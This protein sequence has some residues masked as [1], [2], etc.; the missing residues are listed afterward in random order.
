MERYQ[1]SDDP[2]VDKPILDQIVLGIAHELNNPNGF[3]RMNAMNLKK[4]VALLNPIL[5]EAAEKD[6][7]KK[8]GPYTLPTLRGKILQNIEDILG[9]S[10]RII[11]ISDRLKD[12]TSDA[13]AQ[14]APISLKDLFED[15]IKTHDFIIQRCA[16]LDFTW[17]KDEEYEV[18]AHRLQLDQALSILITN[19]CD[20]I[21][22]RY[23]D[24]DELQGELNINLT[25]SGEEVVVRVRDNGMGM[26]KK[27]VEKI[28]TPYF[29]T[30]P[31]GAGDGLG[32]AIFKT[33]IQRHHGRIEVL[34]KREV[35]TEFRI[36]LPKAGR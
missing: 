3:I 20:T 6:P 15:M 2:E 10:V 1:I 13:L 16:H 24:S 11:V 12:C 4:M 30:K 26:D 28:F 18:M 21:T 7:D 19:A 29:S 33:I 8:F 5:T 9:A 25:Q 23:N 34:S 22:E 27:T 17:D 32:L 31:Q 36:F 35:G 14:H